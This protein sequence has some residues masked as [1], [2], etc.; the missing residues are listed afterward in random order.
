M[1]KT[2]TLI[3]SSICCLSLLCSCNHPKIEKKKIAI[4]APKKEYPTSYKF[5]YSPTDSIGITLKLDTVKSDIKVIGLQLSNNQQF[6][7]LEEDQ[8][9][10]DD[11]RLEM[12]DLNFDGYKE[13]RALKSEGA[14]GNNWFETW[15]YNAPKKKWIRNSFLSNA[16]SVSVDAKNKRIITQYNGGAAAQGLGEYTVSDTTFR[17]FKSWWVE[18]YRDSLK[19]FIDSFKNR[20]LV[21]RD[22]LMTN[23]YLYDVYKLKNGLK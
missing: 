10:L 23:S 11:F 4:A 12:V 14:T 16:C 19:V 1:P 7:I 9:F 13:I 2:L 15:V 21:K 18:R 22:S 8:M 20:R 3:F 5:S 17:I 6:S